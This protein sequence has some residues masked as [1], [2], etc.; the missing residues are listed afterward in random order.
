MYQEIDDI[1]LDN[2]DAEAVLEIFA[3][4]AVRDECMTKEDLDAL[5]ARAGEVAKQEKKSLEEELFAGG[6]E[7]RA[8]SLPH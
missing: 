5:K 3:A 2:P 8:L 6:R 7:A 4:Q 1:K